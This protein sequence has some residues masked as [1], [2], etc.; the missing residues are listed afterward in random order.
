MGKIPRLIKRD[1]QE[2]RGLD[3]LIIRTILFVI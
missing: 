3:L 2:S 1:L